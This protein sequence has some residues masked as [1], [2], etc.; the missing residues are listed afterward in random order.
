MQPLCTGCI[1]DFHLAGSTN[2]GRRNTDRSP[3]TGEM[4]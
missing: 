1:F 2:L 3:I 4:R